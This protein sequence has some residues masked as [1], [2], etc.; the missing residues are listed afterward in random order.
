MSAD[1]ASPTSAADFAV[2]IGISHYPNFSSLPSLA[3]PAGDARTFA[4]WLTDSA[5]VPA[6]HVQLLVSD[7]AQPG[8]PN[9]SEIDKAFQKLISPEEAPRRRLYIY[10]SGHGHAT[11]P[12]NVALLPADASLTITGPAVDAKAYAD[13][14]RASRGFD[15]IVLFVDCAR[16]IETLTPPTGPPFV[17]RVDQVRGESSYLYGFATGYGSTA[18]ETP[19]P[20]GTVRGVFSNALMS[21]LSG[22]AAGSDGAITSQTLA[23][24]V[25]S[26][27]MEA[28]PESR[29]SPVFTLD[30]SRL[31]VFREPTPQST[32]VP[33]SHPPSPPPGGR[34][35]ASPSSVTYPTPRIASDRWAT[36]DA[37]GYGAFA[38]TVATLITHPETLPPLT[39]GIKAPWGAGKTSLMKR[40]QYLLDG[41]ASVTEQN[42]AAWLNRDFEV[43]LT[44]KQLLA[45]LRTLS[46]MTAEPRATAVRR[47]FRRA[48][49]WVRSRFSPPAP[50]PSAAGSPPN[51]DAS[52]PPDAR[53]ERFDHMKGVLQTMADAMSTAAQRLQFTRPEPVLSAE[54]MAA[55]IPARITVWF[56]AWKYQT[57]EQIWAGLAHCIISQVTARM[58]PA[59][60][61]LFWLKLHASRVDI[62]QVRWK[63][64]RMLL[65][66]LLPLLLFSAAILAASLVLLALD[67]VTWGRVGLSISA[68]SGFVTW[69]EGARKLGEKV[70]DDFKELVREPDYEG[71]LGFLHLVESD[72]RDVLDMVATARTPLVVFVDDLDRCAPHQVAEVIEAINLFLSGDYPNCIFV[73]G[74]EPA[75][76]AAALEVANSELLEKVREFGVIDTQV[77]LGWRFMEKIVQLPLAIPS[78]DAD[79]A[80]AYLAHLTGGAPASSALPPPP[81]ADQVSAYL[82]EFK[83]VESV[84]QVV[85]RTDELLAQAPAGMKPAVAEASKRVYAQKFTDRD[86]AIS[87]FI[88]GTIT[89]FQGNPRQLKR[90]VNLFRFFSTLRHTLITDRLSTGRSALAMPSDEVLTKFIALSIHWPQ[91]ADYLRLVRQL[92]DPDAS[93]PERTALLAR[94]EEGAVDLAKDDPDSA[95]ERWGTYLKAIGLE[96]AQW[97]RA[98]SFREFLARGERLGG[99]DQCGLW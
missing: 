7:P 44:L 66:D 74:M 59:S 8:H 94:L 49:V 5:G 53:D 85:K 83:A 71:K 88:Q 56:N 35:E 42:E 33:S 16:D 90:Y 77:P 63:A 81:A 32:S 36:D 30:P 58:S 65:R 99:H 69:F 13:Y 79:G 43:K 37:L 91:A 34:Q 61:E 89:L 51:T 86:P 38:R 23:S 45:G 72:I 6:D 75:I 12:D 31:I 39:I 55:D 57:S 54:G 15:E 95:D 96:Q 29:Q 82:Q 67:I 9:R 22:G 78:P 48:I 18:F 64:R 52:K 21:G 10:M 1:A 98:R 2:V 60:R 27:V 14:F 3:A 93:P 97:A 25:S 4:S 87:R 50:T 20:D 84:D 73:L 41:R 19:Q 62:N 68:L 40:I 24:Y 26:R 17:V 70:S 92:D 76:V 47:T 28:A 11:R 46:R 80:Q